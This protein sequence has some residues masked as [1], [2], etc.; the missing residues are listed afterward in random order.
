MELEPTNDPKTITCTTKASFHTLWTRFKSHMCDP[1]ARNLTVRQCSH[2]HYSKSNSKSA[3]SNFRIQSMYDTALRAKFDCLL[4]DPQW[5]F[6]FSN[7]TSSLYILSL[8]KTW[9]H[10]SST[11][12]GLVW[13]KLQFVSTISCPDV[14]VI[15]WSP[16]THIYWGSVSISSVL[17]DVIEWNFNR[18]WLGLWFSGPFSGLKR[19]CHV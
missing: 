9:L 11:R 18:L 12:Y 8:N 10:V 19:N 17:K 13:R 14:R 7:Y 5:L 16:P 3:C 2:L 4:N 1:K 15:L 6:V